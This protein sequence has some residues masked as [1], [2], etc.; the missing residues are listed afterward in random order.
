MI[1]PW[2]SLDGPRAWVSPLEALAELASDVRLRV[3]HLRTSERG[4]LWQGMWLGTGEG[5]AFEIPWLQV[6]E[7]DAS[8]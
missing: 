2:G 1:A 7:L 5:S 8:G 6:A 3:D 4:V